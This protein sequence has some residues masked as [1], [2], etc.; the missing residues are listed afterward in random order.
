MRT[1]GILCAASVL[2]SCGP[3]EGDLQSDDIGS[4]RSALRSDPDLDVFQASPPHRVRGQASAGPTGLSPAKVRAA[5]NLPSSGGAGT[6]AIIDA[7]DNPK[8][9]SD[10]NVFSAAYGLPSCTTA[11]GCFEK[12]KMANNVRGDSG[13]ALEIAL[14]IQWA[15]AIAPNAKILLVEA[16][17]NSGTDLLAAVD[18]AR[19]RADVVAVSMSWGGAEYAGEGASDSRF[20]SAYGATFFA[21]SGDNGTGVIWPSVSPN[22]TA[23]GGTTLAFN[24]D[25]TLASETAWSGS[26]GGL[27]VYEPAPAYQTASGLVTSAGGKRAVPDVSLNADPASGFSVYDTAGYY[28]QKGWFK[29]GGT[30][31]STPCWAAIKS[32]GLS[33]DNDKFYQDAAGPA[34]ATFFRDVVSGTNGSCGSLCSAG[35]GYDAVTGL[36]SPLATVY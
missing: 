21:A 17:S 31:G 22:V 4:I 26:G 20:T 10:L 33:A 35:P 25:G 29:V 13:W 6:I 23:V 19:S 7:F 3:P 30:S 28:G 27:S 24:P 2:A 16:K 8:A 34:A 14:D 5:Y 36:G 18:Y 11:N 32:L 9:E 1:L 15:H 12:H